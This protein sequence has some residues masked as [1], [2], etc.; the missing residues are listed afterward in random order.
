MGLSVGFHVLVLV[1]IIWLY[2]STP[3]RSPGD[4]L[5]RVAVVLATQEP[6][7]PVEYLDENSTDAEPQDSQDS[8]MTEVLPTTEPPVDSA[9]SEPPEAANDPRLELPGFDASKM[10]RVPQ[11][12]S[13]AIGDGG[14]TAEDLKMIEAERAAFDAKRPKGPPTTI[15]V[16]QSGD[17]TGRRFVFV[18]DRSKSMGSSGLNMLTASRR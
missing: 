14:L 10:S 15:R 4:E 18:L 12:S 3:P 11:N 7:A 2:Q 17:L 1:S 8:E 9:L 6:S 5:R 13:G 16:F